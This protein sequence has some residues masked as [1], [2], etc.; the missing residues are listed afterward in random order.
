M[1]TMRQ[2]FPGRGSAAARTVTHRPMGAMVPGPPPGVGQG[3][4]AG[5][6]GPP[7]NIFGTA[8]RELR[9]S[10]LDAATAI[11]LVDTSSKPRYFGTILPAPQT[12]K[13]PSFVNDGDSV[14]AGVINSNNARQAENKTSSG[15]PRIARS[16]PSRPM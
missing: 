4:F 2:R 12:L 10:L 15:A 6:E 16:L 7:Q 5:N 9:I 3:E 8:L 14:R 13:S 1:L 11:R